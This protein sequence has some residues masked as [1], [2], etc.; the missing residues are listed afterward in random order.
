MWPWTNKSDREKQN[1]LILE[2]F[3][4]IEELAQAAGHLQEAINLLI[5][6]SKKDRSEIE[7]LTEENKEFRDC[8]SELAGITTY[9]IQENGEISK[10]IALTENIKKGNCRFK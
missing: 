4:A 9:I 3:T 6:N 1:E 5:E 7:K 8:L 10:H 2:S